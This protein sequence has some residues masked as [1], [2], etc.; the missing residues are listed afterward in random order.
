MYTSLDPHT[1]THL[2]FG[3]RTPISLHGPLTRYVQLRVAHA[4]GMLGSFSP[5]TIQMK[6]LDSDRGMHHGTCVTHVPWCMS[7]S[8]TRDGGVNVPGIPGACTTRNCTYLARGPY[9]SWLLQLFAYWL[10]D[11]FQSNCTLNFTLG[12]IFLIIQWPI[13]CSICIHILK[14]SLHCFHAPK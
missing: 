6:P 14:T 11:V 9:S 1:D 5:P 4:P 13:L 3:I 7:G 12:S 2:N 8:L 10:R